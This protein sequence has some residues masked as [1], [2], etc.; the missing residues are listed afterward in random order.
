MKEN[1]S[2]CF[3]LNTVWRL[4]GS[5]GP[6][7]GNSIWATRWSRD[8]WRHVTLKRHVVTPIRLECN[9]SKTAGD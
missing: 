8:R 6:P 2:G 9:I 4:I 1:V 3:F 7:I 5:K